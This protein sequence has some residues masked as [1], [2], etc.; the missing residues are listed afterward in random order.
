MASFYSTLYAKFAELQV[1]RSFSAKFV[2]PT[3]AP[4]P[5]LKVGIEISDCAVKIPPIRA[6]KN[7]ISYGPFTFEDGEFGQAAAVKLATAS[8]SLLSAKSLFCWLYRD[9]MQEWLAPKGDALRAGYAINVILDTL[10]RRRIRQV[11]GADFYVDVMQYADLLASILLPRSPKKLEVLGETAVASLIL[12]VP[13]HVPTVILKAAQNFISKLDSLKFDPSRL[14]DILRDRMSN[15]NN[16]KISVSESGWDQIAKLADILYATIDKIPG[17]WHSVYLPYSHALAAGNLDSIFQSMIVTEKEFNMTRQRSTNRGVAVNDAMW[18]EIFFELQREERWKEKTLSKLSRATKDLNFAGTGFPTSD[19]ISYHML[20]TELAPQIRRMVDR[21]RMVKNVLDE[22]AFEESGNIDLQVAIQAIASET[23]RNDI[24]IKDE[25]LLKN[26]SW[27]ILVDSSLS[28]GGSSKEVKAVSICL[29]ETAR[30][31]MGA[32]PWGMYAFSDKLYCIKDYSEP[33]SNQVKARIGGLNHGGLSHIPDA[34]RA[35][36]S[37]IA[38][39]AQDRNYL[40]LVSDGLPSGYPGIEQE[41]AA[42]IKELGKNGIDLAAI[43][44]AG[45]SMKKMIRKARVIEEPAQIV[46][47]FMEIY[48]GL[49]A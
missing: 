46:K 3:S 45:S 7:T 4:L 41:V 49:S 37:L 22:S 5:S 26:E 31:I 25:N 2:Y 35:C 43:G 1:D 34:I 12:N 32:I 23:A 33:Y 28:L 27:T 21:V 40:I 42:S 11:E 13:V 17:K 18:K 6:A 20:Y 30:E 15:D 39:H 8:I 24:F 14:V 38:E 36:R 48:Y 44:V 9:Y 29:A 16:I 47:E 19:Y 10:A